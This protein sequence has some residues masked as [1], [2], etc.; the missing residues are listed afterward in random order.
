MAGLRQPCIADV[1]T[2]PTH[3]PNTMQ[4]MQSLLHPQIFWVFNNDILIVLCNKGWEVTDFWRN[5][6]DTAEGGWRWFQQLR[7]V[8]IM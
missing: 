7:G 5:V 1:L 8:I 6:T 3:S 4:G 2:S